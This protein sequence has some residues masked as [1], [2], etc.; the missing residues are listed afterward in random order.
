M[1][2]ACSIQLTKS[3]LASGIAGAECIFIPDVRFTTWEPFADD[4]QLPWGLKVYRSLGQAL[5]AR[6]SQLR[7]R[8]HGLAPE[9]GEVVRVWLPDRR[10]PRYGY[11]T[12]QIDGE[13]AEG[14]RDLGLIKFD[15]MPDQFWQTI[16]RLKNLGYSDLD[17]HFE[18]LM[19]DNRRLRWVAIDFGAYS[20]EKPKKGAAA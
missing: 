14:M 5:K 9:V 6:Q 10:S 11:F 15:Q 12:E 7:Y 19:F 16:D 1:R 20:N 2:I 3:M 18:N 17:Q 4:R 13:T 8:R